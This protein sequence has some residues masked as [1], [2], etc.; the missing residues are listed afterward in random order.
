[1]CYIHSKLTRR[2]KRISY[3]VARTRTTTDQ[4][5]EY[6]VFKLSLYRRLVGPCDGTPAP[7][8]SRCGLLTALKRLPP[9]DTR[10]HDS[11]PSALSASESCSS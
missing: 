6:I 4:V 2:V 9:A 8:T 3:D 5:E 11:L 7:Q 10:E 1:M